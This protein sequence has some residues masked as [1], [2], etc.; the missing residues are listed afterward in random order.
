MTNGRFPSINI[1]IILSLILGH[2]TASQQVRQKVSALWRRNWWADIV[3]A[4]AQL[5]LHRDKTVTYIW[6]SSPAP[7]ILSLK[8]LLSSC[9]LSKQR[10]GHRWSICSTRGDKLLSVLLFQTTLPFRLVHIVYMSLCSNSIFCL[11]YML[12]LLWLEPP[13]LQVSLDVFL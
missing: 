13:R 4:E 10:Y 6:D 12:K 5:M 9:F 7:C 1:P 3:S 2:N 8:R 11:E